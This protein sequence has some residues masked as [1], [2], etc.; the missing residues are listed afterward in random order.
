MNVF[1]T[2]W[3]RGVSVPAIAFASLAAA[4]GEAAPALPPWTP[5]A[6]AQLR[7]Q[8]GERLE[9]ARARLHLPPLDDRGYVLADVSLDRKRIFTNYSGDISGRMI[10]VEAYL[11]RL[12]PSETAPLQAL[13]EGAPT[14]QKPDGHFGAPQKLPQFDRATD[15][16]IL[17]GNGRIL[18][19]LAEAFEETGDASALKA[20]RKLGDYF[21]ATDP[22]YCKTENLSKVGGEAADAF[23]TCYFSCIEGLVALARDTGDARY[24]T[25]AERISALTLSVQPAAPLHSHGRLSALRGVLALYELTGDRKWLDGVERD[26][27]TFFERYRLATGGITEM[28]ARGEARDEGCAVADWLR[29]NLGLWRATGQGRYLDEAE[30][31]LKNHFLYQ[32]FANGGSGHRVMKDIGGEPVAFRSGGTD[33]YWC[34]CE[35]WPRAMVDVTRLGITA[36]PDGAS[37]NL[38]VDVKTS[39]TIRDVPCEVT[40][41]ETAGGLRIVFAP[42]KPVEAVLGI[43]RPAWAAQ[44]HVTVPAGLT[45]HE[46]D[47]QWQIGG[48]WQHAQTLQV[49]LA[50]QVRT[51]RSAE[52]GTVFLLG[53]D[54]LVAHATPANAWLFQADPKARPLV[55]WDGQPPPTGAGPLRVLATAD[56]GPDAKWRTLEL[57]PMRAPDGA[58]PHRCWFS[59]AA[60]PP[61]FST[62]AP[63]A[64]A[65]YLV[66]GATGPCRAFLN[67]RAAG[68][69]KNAQSPLDVFVEGGAPKHNEL[70]VVCE[71][72]TNASSAVGVVAAISDAS[73]IRATAG[74]GWQVRALTPEESKQDAAALSAGGDWSTASV[75][76]PALIP[77]RENRYSPLA[78]LTD[79]WLTGPADIAHPALAFRLVW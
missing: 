25:Q 53:H 7:G 61:A 37:V 55:Q 18:I 28:L 30:R 29:L 23:S 3:L 34:C 76:D 45:V 9:R 27:R 10:G 13:L 74:P 54:L 70:I 14:F 33:A 68:A 2:Q 35:H 51:E 19:G 59:F 47:G 31:C 5:I 42:A 72:S 43:H 44:A 69:S 75:L 39:L 71:P 15:M 60:T 56:T 62:A 22:L 50:P 79:H 40:T 6:Q 26:W 12:F 63:A 65:A 4:G 73:G 41:A 78:D 46:A 17:W 58:F 52:G 11:A 24:R 8:C 64:P 67:G 77:S 38:C 48:R 57:T 32:Q 66:A 16:P 49:D 20:A 1:V 36:T 21:V